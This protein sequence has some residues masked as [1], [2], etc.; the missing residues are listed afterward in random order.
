MASPA[1]SWPTGAVRRLWRNPDPTAQQLD[2][3]QVAGFLLNLCRLCSDRG[4]V[5]TVQRFRKQAQHDRLIGGREHQVV[6]RGEEVV[7]GVF[8]GWVICRFSSCR[9][10]SPRSGSLQNGRLEGSGWLI[11]SA[12]WLAIETYSSLPAIF[13][14]ENRSKS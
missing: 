1:S 12:V 14:K 13:A 3:S 2:S 6:D 8:I 11:L 5:V 9:A 10:R 7:I 4:G